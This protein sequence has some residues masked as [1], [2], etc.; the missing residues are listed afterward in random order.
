MKN[1]SNV[2]LIIKESKNEKKNVNGDHFTS[3]VLWLYF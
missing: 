3:I 2:I 1:Q